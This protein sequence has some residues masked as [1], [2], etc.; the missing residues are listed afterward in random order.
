MKKKTSSIKQNG[1]FMS[2]Q[3]V[4]VLAGFLALALLAI[5]VL[6]VADDVQTI[7][8]DPNQ[9]NKPGEILKLVFDVSSLFK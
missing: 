7:I 4:A 8:Q 5:H 1:A 9:A 6:T 2:K 3:D